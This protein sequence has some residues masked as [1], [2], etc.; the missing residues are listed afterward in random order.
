MM[1]S[2]MC[3]T[4]IYVM[5]LISLKTYLI[6]QAFPWYVLLNYFDSGMLKKVY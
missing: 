5:F 4:P 1:L 2:V 6:A 3:E